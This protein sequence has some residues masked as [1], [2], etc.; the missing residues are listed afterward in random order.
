MLAGYNQRA[1]YEQALETAG[2]IPA[3]AR[4]NEPD[5]VLSMSMENRCVCEFGAA[6]DEICDYC[7]QMLYAAREHMLLKLTMEQCEDNREVLR[8]SNDEIAE[9][10]KGAVTTQQMEEAIESAFENDL[11]GHLDR[12]ADNGEILT[13]QGC[14][15][16]ID[17]ALRDHRSDFEDDIRDALVDYI[18]SD[19]TIREIE[20]HIESERRDIDREIA[21]LDSKLAALPTTFGERL[22]WLFTGVARRSVVQQSTQHG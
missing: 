13:E 6:T 18:D 4:F 22:R 12:A 11:S 15:N 1:G 16:L 21:E 20:S 17:E 5:E 2:T 8:I 19:E 7:S 10:Q 9:L 3:V 14:S